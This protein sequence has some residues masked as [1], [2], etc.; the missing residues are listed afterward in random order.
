M[1]FG[2]TGLHAFLA[3]KP[4]A[5]LDTMI[6]RR[7]NAPLASS[8]GRL[9]DAV[10]AALDICREHQSYEGEA[11][12][13]LEA[14]AD[15]SLIEGEDEEYPLAIPNLPG[16]GLPY[17][18]PVGLWRAILG[19]IWLKTPPSVISARFHRWLTNAVAAMTVKLARR[20]A[21]GGARFDTV[22]LSGG[23]FHNAILFSG[24]TRRLEAENFTVLSHVAVPAN[25]GGL[26]FGQAAIGA[27]RLIA[28]QHHTQGTASCVSE[29][30]AAS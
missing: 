17:I 30:P 8:C 1:N 19:D 18:E 4:R 10:A 24:L 12:Q 7:L 3:E 20:S 22:A 2:D 13:R 9:F 26:A 5:M 16:A 23:C 6:A 11:A 27:A 28:R 15:L 14:I 25:D 29:F 21:P